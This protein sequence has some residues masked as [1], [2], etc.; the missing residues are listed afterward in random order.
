MDQDHRNASVVSC[1]ATPLD[2][3][4]RTSSLVASKAGNQMNRI[5]LLRGS[6][7]A[8]TLTHFSAP[9]KTSGSSKQDFL[10]PVFSPAFAHQTFLPEHYES[11][12]AYP[13]LIWLHS[14]R[15]S[16][17]EIGQIMPPLSCRNYVAVGL[18]GPQRAAKQRRLFDW[19]HSPNDVAF[20]EECIFETIRSISASVSIHPE[21]VFLAGMGRGGT[22]AQYIGLRHPDRFAG[23]ASINGPFPAMPRPLSRWKEAKGLPIL[24]MHGNDS[25]QCGMDH[26]AEMLQKVYASALQVFP[27]QFACGDELDTQM[28]KKLNRFMM[29]IVTGESIRLYE[30][31]HAE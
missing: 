26:M 2:R 22:L 28:L 21:R 14:D 11:G 3:L 16:E 13:L 29:Q 23:I 5:E 15:S 25:S 1:D 7:K 18:R 6:S 24:W 27:V 31:L 12:Y 17:G 4:P 19:G 8:K 20:A 9:A 10:R 30:A